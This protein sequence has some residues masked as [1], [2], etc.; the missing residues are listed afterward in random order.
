M[1]GL[2]GIGLNALLTFQ[3]ALATTGHNIANVNTPGYHRQSVLLGS[4]AG[5][6]I[7]VGYLGNGVNIN[8]VRR[9]YDAFLEGQLA[10]AISGF[11]QQQALA[12]LS[13][14][15]GSLFGENG[16]DV[17]GPVNDLFTT[18]GDMAADPTSLP[19]RNSVLADAG[20][21]ADRF[22][23]M[24]SRLDSTRVGLNQ[25]LQQLAGEANDLLSNI[26]QLNRRIMDVAG[27]PA[28]N[29]LLDQRE[30]LVNRLAEITDITT[31]E[32]DDG[33]LNVSL[34]NGLNL[35]LGS[36][37]ETLS[38]RRNE[39]DPARLELVIGPENGIQTEISAQISGGELGGLLQFRDQVLTPTQNEIGRIALG[40]A[41]SINDQHRQGMDLNG[42]LGGNLFNIGTADVLHSRNNTGNGQIDVIVEDIGQLTPDDFE[43]TFDG[44]NWSMTNLTNGQAVPLTPD[45]PD[46]VG[47]GMR[48]Q[49]SSLPDAGDR[50]QIRPTRSAAADINVA[51]SD[52]ALL[53]AASAL[54][55]ATD[56]SNQGSG[57]VGPVTITDP[58]DPQLR[59]PV[60]IV[61]DSPTTFRINGGPPQSYVAG[62]PI[63]VNGWEITIDGAPATGDSFSVTAS[64]A[65]DQGNGANALALADL[66][67][68]GLLDGGQTSVSAGYQNVVA[69]LGSLGSSF[70]TAAGIQGGLLSDLELRRD[71]ASGVNLDEEA[72]LLQQYQQSYQAA[73][74]IIEAA[75]NTF[76]TLLAATRR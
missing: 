76:Q 64:T 58:L 5:T 52:P 44:A 4:Q 23:L 47:G 53:A 2:Q 21:M 8:E 50:F 46:L 35:V 75:S 57:L 12:Q 18:L 68:N 71:A 17:Y 11:H 39:F 61:F 24:Q 25:R 40:I 59:D 55:A 41:M 66:Q 65:A 70:A 73:A 43:L 33:A 60:D 13:D 20:G 14:G 19:A 45:G 22:R 32:T 31:L 49:I 56:D 48:I 67:L 28:P 30:S 34:A 15:L 29:D 16:I 74:Q 72:V 42:N 10:G 69:R 6:F 54:V 26:A 7:G 38:T 36:Q 9:S 1:S 63:A 3:R 62:S 51:F 37:A 27:G